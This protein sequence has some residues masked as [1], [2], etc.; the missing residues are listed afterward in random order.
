MATSSKVLLSRPL[1]LG[2]FRLIYEHAGSGPRVV[3]YRLPCNLVARE[4]EW[5]IT[6]STL[7]GIVVRQPFGCFPTLT[8]L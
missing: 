6:T 7:E 1:A 3:T 2:R 5:C 8:S 4:A